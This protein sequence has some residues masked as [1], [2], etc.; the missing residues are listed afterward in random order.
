MNLM[1]VDISDIPGVKLEEPVTLIGGDENE[2]ISAEQLA[3]WANTLNYEI[4]S[5]INEK[6]VRIVV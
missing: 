6:I 4:I 5:R 2:S 3:G 1:M